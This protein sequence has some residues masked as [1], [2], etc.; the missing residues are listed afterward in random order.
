MWFEH[1]YG[2]KISKIRIYNISKKPLKVYVL[3][4]IKKVIL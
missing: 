3:D 1:I 2:S 4:I